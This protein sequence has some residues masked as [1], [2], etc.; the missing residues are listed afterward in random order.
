MPSIITIFGATGSQ[1][2]SVLNAVH[3]SGE[4]KIRAVTRNPDSDAS[5]ALL[6]RGVELVKADLT[7]KDSLYKA[8]RG[9]DIVFATTMPVSR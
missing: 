6:S 9:S 5:K 2:G 1:G 8:V 7:D 3:A 4:F